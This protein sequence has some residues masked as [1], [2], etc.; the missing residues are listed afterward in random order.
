M[1]FATVNGVRLAYDDEGAG[2]P[3]VLV[4]GSWTNRHGWD[5]VAPR[6][7]ERFRVVR[8]DRRGHSE[9]E[10]VPGTFDDDV[11]DII[12]LAEH[13]ELERFALACSSQGGAVGLRLAAARPDL[14]PAVVCHEPPLADLVP[15]DVQMPPEIEAVD[16]TSGRVVELIDAGEHRE[17]AR[18]FVEEV[19]FGPGA[20]EGLPRAYRDMFVENASTFADESRDP[21]GNGVDPGALRSLDVPVLLTTSDDSLPWLA[22]IVERAAELLPRARVHRYQG[23]G[24][25]PQ[26][27]VPDEY[28]RVVGD[29]VAAPG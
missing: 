18:L 14:V 13:L 8:H 22:L 17:A 3:L 16:R 26:A 15:G 11:R 28:A 2:S 23:A 12:A 4:H 6:L 25:A 27:M 21:T 5:L 9:S 20:W 10:D 19:A 29:F 7:A 1:A 24:H